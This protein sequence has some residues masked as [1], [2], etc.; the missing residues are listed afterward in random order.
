M[1]NQCDNQEQNRCKPASSKFSKG[2]W[3]IDIYP[4]REE[5]ILNMKACKSIDVS[6]PLEHN[7]DNNV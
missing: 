4:K 6:Y 3:A 5:H 7:V 2:L 1:D